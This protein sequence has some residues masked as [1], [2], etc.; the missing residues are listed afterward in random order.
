MNRVQK[1]KD[2]DYLVEVELGIQGKQGVYSDLSAMSNPKVKSRFNTENLLEKIVDKRNFFKAYKKVVANKG[3]YGIDGMKVD[4]LLPFLQ[5]RYETLKADLL[6]G[7]YKLQSKKSRNTQ[8][9]WRSKTT[10][11]TNCSR[12]INSTGNKPS[13]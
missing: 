13:D 9:K 11:N 3:S 6:S 10:W 12:W 1:T 7:K 2:L 8:A 5:E 4:E